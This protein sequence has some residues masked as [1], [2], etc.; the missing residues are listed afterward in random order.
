MRRK[1]VP[2]VSLMMPATGAVCRRKKVAV[3]DA[4]ISGSEAQ[5]DFPSQ[6][7][8]QIRLAIL[9][10][11]AIMLML[12][13]ICTGL[14]LPSGFGQ[15]CTRVETQAM[16]TASSALRL[17]TAMR[18]NGMFTDIVPLIPGSLTFIRD[19]AA[20]NVPTARA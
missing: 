9:A 18:K 13:S 10:A 16:A 2:S 3:A 17:T 4:S 14:N 1:A 19:V 12:K 11:Q 15:H 6:F 8:C 20:A 5:A 7:E